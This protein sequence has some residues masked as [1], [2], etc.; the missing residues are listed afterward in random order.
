M[1]WFINVF[2]ILMPLL[3]HLNANT[4]E[5]RNLFATE[6]FQTVATQSQNENVI[7]SP[8]SVQTA[9]GLVYYGASGQTASELQKSLHATAHQSKDGLAQGYHKL[10]HSFIKSKT[11]L[12]IA[13]KIFVN[14]KL[15][16]SPEFKR[17]S[18]VYFDSDVEQLDFANETYSVDHINQWLAEKTN[19]KIDNVIQRLDPDT[20]VAL[21]NAI[22]FKAK[23]ARPFMDDATSDREFWISNEQ[24]I[25]VP[26]MFADNWY[27]YA[28]Y[29]DLDAKALELFF[30]NIDLTMWFILPNKR[31]GLFELEQKLKGVNFN[32]LEAL[33][34]WKSTSVYL[35]KFKFEFDTD[36]KPSL[37]KLGI[38][39]MFSNSADFSNMFDKRAPNMH[40]SQV[41][42]KAFIDVNEIGCE[43]AAA[44]VAVGVP[45]SL[46]IDP[47]TFVADHPFVFIIRDKTAVYFAGHIVKL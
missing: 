8:V 46:P 38:N 4:V 24:S 11:V 22:Y 28:E 12:E 2:L 6:L 1:S 41:Q 3:G 25:K 16:I 36:L 9:L 35:P 20:N 43:A 40:I 21:I 34:E 33:W 45:M 37:Q 17:T 42:H 39:T 26:T 29:P 13:N 23:W 14:D 19:G 15:E 18:Q 5:E 47:K 27:Y 10:L 30:E 7:I 32:D 44:S 31:D